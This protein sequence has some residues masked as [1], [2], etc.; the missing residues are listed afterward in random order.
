MNRGSIDAA[1]RAAAQWVDRHRE[2]IEAFALW[3]KVNEAC[4]AA[5]LYAPL[6]AQA[7]ERIAADWRRSADPAQSAAL[8]LS[9]YGPGGSA[10][11][12]L[13]DDML[14]EPLLSDR[15]SQVEEVLASVADQRPYV[16]IC[17]ALPLFEG[18]LAT[19]AGKWREPLDQPLLNRLHEPDSL[20]AAEE[21]EL[22]LNS[23]AVEMLREALP[24]YWKRGPHRPGAVTQELRRHLVLH[25]T[26]SG[27]DNPENATRALLLVAAAARVAGP[28]L[29]PGPPS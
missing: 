20:T 7:W 4:R 13:A 5:G 10:H 11:A 2:E 16:A 24:L 27:W 8:I 15:R 19:A 28:L 12:T 1:L 18:A 26:A 6:D 14:A 21:G 3:G 9:L 25:G 22:I 29:Q 17:G 23:A